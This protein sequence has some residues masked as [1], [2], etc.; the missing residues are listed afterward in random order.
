MQ[1]I[2][3]IKLLQVSAPGCH[4]QGDFNTKE[5]MPNTLKYYTARFGMFELQLF[6]Y[7]RIL[8]F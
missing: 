7:F 6:I 1:F 5:Y 2:R 4:L 8:I 3:T